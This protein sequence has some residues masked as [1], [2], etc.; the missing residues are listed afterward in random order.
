MTPP[1]T[2]PGTEQHDSQHIQLGPEQFYWA[3]LDAASLGRR[4]SSRA[5][6][7][8]FES[9]LPVPIDDVQAVYVKMDANSYIACGMDKEWL[10]ELITLSPL[11]LTPTQLPEFLSNTQDIDASRFNLLVGDFAPTTLRRVKRMRS[12]VAAMIVLILAAALT[13]GLER[14]VSSLNEQTEFLR[15]QQYEIAVAVLGENVS[16]SSLPPALQLTAELRELQSTRQVDTAAL[17]KNDASQ[18]L[19]DLFAHWPRELMLQTA[20]V[21]IT[22]QSISIHAELQESSA[23]QSLTEALEPMHDWILRQPRVDVS[24]KST[25][26]TIQLTKR[27]DANLPEARQ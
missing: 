8:M 20:S 9:V 4:A 26:A 13:V 14:R 15:Q 19:A 25:K 1:T 11:T 3:K 10:N 23:A 6:G 2:A 18:T 21:S 27:P 12:S 5:L 17:D 7:Y 22:D 24:D 16:K